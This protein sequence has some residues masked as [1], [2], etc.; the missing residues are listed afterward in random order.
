[1]SEQP[2][3]QPADALHGARG[4]QLRG[5]ARTRCERWIGSVA[6]SG[7]AAR[8]RGGAAVARQLVERKVEALLAA[9]CPADAARR[10]LLDAIAA[11]APLA[12]VF[13]PRA[14]A[15][16]LPGVSGVL[17]VHAQEV[18]E[19]E[20]AHVIAS[21][22]SPGRAIE[23]LAAEAQQLE[24]QIEIA[25]AANRLFRDA[26]D[27]SDPQEWIGPFRDMSLAMAEYLHR[28]AL[29]IEQRLSD[30]VAMSYST[31]IARVQRDGRP[32]PLRQRG[33]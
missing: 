17:S 2:V 11:W 23:L 25:E 20:Y 16:Q 30:A 26:D 3:V 1:M 22:P 6:S 18:L 19:K 12:V 7:A 27:A 13:L 33:A 31:Q 8:T 5:I 14:P 15:T 10:W 32:A 21:A 28:Q 29:G 4:E 24:L 9:R